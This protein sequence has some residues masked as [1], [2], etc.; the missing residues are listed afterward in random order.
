VQPEAHEVRG[1]AD[2]LVPPAY[3]TIQAAIDAAGNADA[4]ERN[5]LQ[6]GID[7]LAPASSDS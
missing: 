3:A 7:E 1:G 6:F 5:R 2:R 4:V